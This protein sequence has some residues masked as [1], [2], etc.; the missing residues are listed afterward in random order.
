MLFVHVASLSGRPQDV[1][2]ASL[3]GRPQDM[4]E[5]SPSVGGPQDVGGLRIW[6]RPP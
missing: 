1:G 2:E 4:G 6:V 3:S 5:A